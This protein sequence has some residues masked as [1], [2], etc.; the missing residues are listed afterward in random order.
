MIKLL[1]GNREEKEEV[2]RQVLGEWTHLW[3]GTGDPGRVSNVRGL[4]R[5]I[6]LV[7]YLGSQEE[8]PAAR[9][10]NAAMRWG[11]KKP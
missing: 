7:Q 2:K 11:C 6:K 1:G 3:E 8:K 9:V 10:S 5:R 4:L